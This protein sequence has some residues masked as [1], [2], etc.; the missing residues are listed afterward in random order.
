M[1]LRG[2]WCACIS[3]GTNI[4]GNW[5][6]NCNKNNRSEAGK[7]VSEWLEFIKR[8]RSEGGLR[9]DYDVVIGPVADDNT[10]ETIQLYIANILTANEAIERLRFNKVDNQISFHTE[11]ALESLKMVRRAIYE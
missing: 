10:M 7:P 1:P 9:H 11:K 5:S 2:F 3:G 4:Y 6:D 8:N